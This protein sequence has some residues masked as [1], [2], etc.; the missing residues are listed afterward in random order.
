M[1]TDRERKE[2][3]VKMKAER[4]ERLEASSTRKRQMQELEMRRKQNEKP[5]DL[6]QVCDI[7]M[8]SCLRC[9]RDEMMVYCAKMK[10]L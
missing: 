2:R 4:E 6:E 3:E 1:L 7:V 5:S 10:V 8:N 9:A